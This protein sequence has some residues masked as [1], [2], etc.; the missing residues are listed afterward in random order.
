MFCE[1]FLRASMGERAASQIGRALSDGQIH[2][3]NERRVQCRRV[4]GVGKPFSEPPRRAH[5]L[6]S[7][8]RN[9]AIVSSRLE[10]LAVERRGTKDATDDLLVELESVGDD[11]GQ[12]LDIHAVR[13]ILQKSERVSVASSAGHRRR[14]EPRPHLD[15]DEHPRWPRLAADEG[16]QFIGLELFDDETGY[17]ALVEAMANGGCMLKPAS[18]GVPGNPLDPSNRG[19]A[20]TLDPE[21]NNRV[22]TSSSMLETVVRRALGRGERLSARDAPVSTAFPGSRSVE[23]VVDDVPGTDASMDRTYGIRTSAILQFGLALVDERTV[24]L[25]IGLK[26]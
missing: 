18:D 19:N 21:S 20:D 6:S 9:D 26:L 23:T 14:P 2:P 1:L 10:H 12:T 22:E 24:S 15:G 8:D 4:L 13:D 16:A 17:P 7:F 3:F 11:Q 5:P 25:E